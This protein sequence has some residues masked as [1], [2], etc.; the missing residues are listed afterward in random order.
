MLR[1][2]TFHRILRRPVDD[3]VALSLGTTCNHFKEQLKV[4]CG[5][6]K[7]RTLSKTINLLIYATWMRRFCFPALCLTKHCQLEVKNIKV[8]K[9]QRTGWLFC[10]V[11]IWIWKTSS[12]WKSSFRNLNNLPVHMDEH[13]SFR[14]V[15]LTL[16]QKMN[17]PGRH[18]LI[19]WIIHQLNHKTLS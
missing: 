16:W 17:F 10:C 1:K 9:H 8:G 4:T 2:W 14:W 6:R 18:V 12:D 7:C 15:R 3:Y 5:K 19:F 13:C 11:S